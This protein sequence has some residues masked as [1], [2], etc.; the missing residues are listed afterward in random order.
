[1]N[2]QFLVFCAEGFAPTYTKDGKYGL[3]LFQRRNGL[4]INHKID[5]LGTC[6]TL[7][8]A[9][10]LIERKPVEEPGLFLGTENPTKG[11]TGRKRSK[12]DAE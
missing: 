9:K 4:S 11:K 6:E 7:E 12:K 3:T 5:I 10:A 1:M 2:E 8:E